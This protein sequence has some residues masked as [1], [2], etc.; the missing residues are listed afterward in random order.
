MLCL[1]WTIIP[2]IASLAIQSHFVVSPGK[3]LI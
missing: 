3:M 1:V 2:D